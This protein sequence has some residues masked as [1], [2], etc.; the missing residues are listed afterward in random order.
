MADPR[1]IRMAQYGT[2]H[3]HADGVLG[4]M[5][6]NP[7]VEVVGLYEPDAD[8]RRELESS[9]RAPWSQ[10][11]WLDDRRRQRRGYLVRGLQSG[12]S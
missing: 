8:R 11:R 1:T 6:A 2:K 4:V 5:L 7:D 10:V 3:G 12:K 9:G